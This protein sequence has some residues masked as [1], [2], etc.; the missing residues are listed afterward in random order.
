MSFLLSLL[1]SNECAPGIREILLLFRKLI[2]TKSNIQKTVPVTLV[3][4]QQMWKRNYCL[5]LLFLLYT[6][7]LEM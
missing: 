5:M 2:L 4:S 3:I 1:N 6:F 7:F